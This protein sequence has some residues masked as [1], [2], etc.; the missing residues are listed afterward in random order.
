MLSGRNADLFDAEPGATYFSHCPLKGFTAAVSHVNNR[1]STL[2]RVSAVVE[3]SH[4]YKQWT[5]TY[6]QMFYPLIPQIH[7]INKH[8][9]HHHHYHPSE[10]K[11]L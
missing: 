10:F 1:S 6:T 5:Y 2:L 3:Q 11:R 8:H 9:H 7:T 4:Q